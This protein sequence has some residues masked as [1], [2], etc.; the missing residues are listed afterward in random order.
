MIAKIKNNYKVY[1]L[2]FLILIALLFALV[3]FISKPMK[4]KVSSVYQEDAKFVKNKISFPLEQEIVVNDNNL[5][6]VYIYFGD[7]SIN[8]YNYQVSL[9]DGDNVLFENDYKDYKSNI[10]FLGFELQKVVNG[11]KL[12]LSIQ[13]KDCDEVYADV[14]NNSSTVNKSQLL[15]I[16]TVNYVRQ[17]NYYWYSIMLIVFCLTLLP[18]AKE[19][20]E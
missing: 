2:Y 8:S 10:L 17:Y 7:D 1:I 14:V 13:C 9:K 11:K 5:S 16:S 3:V 15:K 19:E 6:G 20:S 12:Q 18:L 4:L